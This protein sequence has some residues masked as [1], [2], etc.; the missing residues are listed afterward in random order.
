MRGKHETRTTT[1][2]HLKKSTKT[3]V[4]IDTTYDDNKKE[5]YTKDQLR[6]RGMLYLL[7]AVIAVLYVMWGIHLTN[8]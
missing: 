1:V 6:L 3:I 2:K 5:P 7:S 4:Q 8:K